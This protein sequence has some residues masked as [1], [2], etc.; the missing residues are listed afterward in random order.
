[1]IIASG[2]RSLDY[3]KDNVAEWIEPPVFEPIENANNAVC[4]S[5]EDWL[6]K[7]KPTLREG[8]KAWND[9]K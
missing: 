7:I 3:K 8:S 5:L 9:R 2:M 6:T 1:M 4:F